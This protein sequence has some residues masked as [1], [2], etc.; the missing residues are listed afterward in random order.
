MNRPRYESGS[1]DKPDVRSEKPVEYPVTKEPSYLDNG[2]GDRDNK[3]G[4]SYSLGINGL[5]KAYQN[6]QS[7]TGAWD[8]DFNGHV[9]LYD[10]LSRLC[11][12]S[13]AEKAESL[14]IMLRDDALSFYTRNYKVGDS[15]VGII[16][17]MREWYTSEE[18]RNRLLHQWQGLRLTK[19]MQEAPEKSEIEVFRDL[20]NRLTQI[21][22]QLDKS[23]RTD[24]FLRDQLLVA[25]D[26]TSIKQSMR[27]RVPKTAQEATQ[28]IA[29]FLSSEAGSAGSN[30]FFNCDTAFNEAL[31]SLGSKY[32]GEAKRNLKGYQ[33]GNRKGAAKISSKWFAGVKGCYVCG[34][35]HMARTRHS[36]DEIM[37]AIKKLKEKHSKAL[38]SVEDLAMITDDLLWDGEGEGNKDDIVLSEDEAEAGYIACDVMELHKD[39]EVHLANIS[40][41]HGR[42]FNADFEREMVMMSR[43]LACG[44]KTPFKGIYID[45]C[46]NRSSVMSIAQYKAYCREFNVPSQIN[47]TDVKALRGIGGSSTAF[48]SAIIPVPFKDLNLVIDIKFRIVKDN[49]PTLLAMKDMVENGLDISIQRRVVKYKHLEHP[50]H[51]ENFFLI[52]RWGRGD[53]A[54]SLYTETE[55]KRLHRTFGHPTV[56]ALINLLRRANP[57]EMNAEA[58]KSLQEITNSCT[59][60]VQNASRPRRFKVTIGSDDLRFNHII[61]VDVMYLSGRAI[62]HIVDEATH[63]NAASFLRKMSS[64]ETWKTIVRCWT[65]VYLGPP[66]FLRVDQGTN[67][68]SKEFCASAEAEG[69]KVLP[70]PIESPE[71]LSHV[72][73]YHAPLRAAYT[74]IRSS[75]GRSES[76]ADVLQMAV[77]AVN[78]TIGPEGLCPTLLVYGAIPRPAKLT[79]AETQLARAK[80]LDSAMDS[81][82]K[83][84]AKRR[85]AFALKHYKGPKGKEDSNKLL[86]LPAFSPVYVY[87]T[88]TTRWEGP[89][90]FIQIDGETCVVQLPSGRK[91]FRSTAVRRS[92][93]VAEKENSRGSEARDK[94]VLAETRTQPDKN[95]SEDDIELDRNVLN[96][97]FGDSD[98]KVADNDEH[99]FCQSRQTEL[100]GLKRRET[101]EIVQMNAIPKRTQ[102]YGSRWVDTIKYIDGKRKE[103][104]RLVSQNFRDR[105]ASTIATKSPTVSRLGQR[106]AVATAAIIPEHTSYIRDIS[107][108]YV[109]SESSLER[110]IYLYPPP[111]MGLGEEEVLLVKKPLYGI[112]ESGLH[113]FLTYHT[114]HVERLGMMATK[115]DVCVLYKRGE[116]TPKGLVALQVDDSYGHGEEKFLQ[117][118]ETHSKRFQCKPRTLLT[119]GK[120]AP[121]N[122]TTIRIQND[123]SHHLEQSGKLRGLCLPETQKDLVSVRAQAQYIGCCTRPDLC[124]PVQLL[125]P[126][127]TQ[128]TRATFSAMKKIVQWCHDTSDIGLRYIPLDMETLRLCLFTDASFANTHELKS[129]WICCRAHRWEQQRKHNSLRKHEM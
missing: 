2:K 15:Y 64:A 99:D 48:G 46:A 127:V 4:S 44:E 14:P 98:L 74:K 17:K 129:T 60:C 7:Y 24:N 113:W 39:Q 56:E 1:Q 26:L 87:R 25:A 63:Y 55:L 28:R 49:V 106:I 34:K 108:A 3:C 109:Q 68:V 128:P 83:E 45:T 86:T 101:F 79:P 10:T 76:D 35:N 125:A 103:K 42:T 27:E 115:G 120:P 5:M 50:L 114:H 75:L 57:D 92:V 16:T 62:L 47:K 32:G 40:F 70:A 105:G 102:I 22:R 37:A 97:M 93:P 13:D 36:R 11:G 20:S 30:A 89:Y 53:L 18:Q 65:A 33:K 71:T 111:E 41:V 110:S 43:E 52:H 126:D 77:K 88:S 21:Q 38:L 67:F 124:A 96:A 61:A 104:S 58:R 73:R 19:A 54:Y 84:Q 72:E 80:A 117:E 107:Q 69:I 94:E 100:E 118:E 31:Y 6:R 12:L 9:E 95:G 116:T 8:E 90:P 51:M 123:G 59:V 23:Y 121:F 82:R 122:G 91:I 78:D 119:P 29:T 112:P 81:V 66:D 85:V